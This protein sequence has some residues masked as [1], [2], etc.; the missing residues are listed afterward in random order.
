MFCV[1]YV[2]IQQKKDPL[3]KWNLFLLLPKRE[4]YLSSSLYDNEATINLKQ[5]E[6]FDFFFINMR[7]I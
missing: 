3:L 1:N 5:F 7:D 6:I 4:N 2:F